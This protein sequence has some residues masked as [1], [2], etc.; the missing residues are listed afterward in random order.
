MTRKK[1]CQFPGQPLCS[2]R[3]FSGAALLLQLCDLSER[4]PG[5][6]GD[7]KKVGRAKAAGRLPLSGFVIFIAVADGRVEHRAALSLIRPDGHLDAAMLELGGGTVAGLGRLIVSPLCVALCHEF[8]PLFGCWRQDY[9]KPNATFKRVLR[10][11]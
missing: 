4:L 7:D 8:P 10:N 6:F 3:L 1:G 5:Q 2:V 9:R 11:R